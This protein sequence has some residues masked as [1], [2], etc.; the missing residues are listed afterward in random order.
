[1][2]L[3]IEVRHLTQ[4]LAGRLDGLKPAFE[5]DVL[6]LD[7]CRLGRGLGVYEEPRTL[8]AQVVSGEVHDTVMHREEGGCCGSGAG[9]AET[10]PVHAGTV[11]REAAADAPDLPVVTAGVSCVEH[12]RAE[13]GRPVHAWACLVA[14]G[15]GD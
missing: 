14:A 5:G 9:Y 15:L 13:V 10:H 4:A 3:D 2:R 12:L 6:Y 1:M 11:A 8:L 7:A